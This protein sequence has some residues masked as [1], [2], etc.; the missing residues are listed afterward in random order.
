MNAVNAKAW[1]V[2]QLTLA[3]TAVLL[4]AWFVFRD[5][6]G[7]ERV[8]PGVPEPVV[9]RI[10]PV[11]N[12]E[13]PLRR[14]AKMLDAL[15]YNAAMAVNNEG[16]HG[17]ADNHARIEDTEKVAMANCA[18]QGPGCRIILR[19]SPETPVEI[20]GLPLSRTA[21]EALRSYVDEPRSKA[22]A[23]TG[24]GGWGAAWDR[25]SRRAAVESALENCRK[26]EVTRAPGLELRAECRIIWAD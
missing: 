5:G 12:Y 3:L 21:A 9:E 23:V 25:R 13:N 8:P 22:I 26:H 20:D 16:G 18:V 7:P 11:P 14:H 2:G 17:W 4:A 6:F 1:K 15:D 19:I 24:H 10:G